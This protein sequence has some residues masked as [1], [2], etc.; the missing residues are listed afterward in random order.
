MLGVPAARRAATTRA[1]SP[2]I[3]YCARIDFPSQ[4]ASSVQ[5][6]HT[7]YELA[8]QGATVILVVRRLLRSRAECFAFYGL[9]EH[10]RLRIVSLALPMHGEFNDWKGDVFRSYLAAFLHRQRSAFTVLMTRDPA[11]MELLALYRTLRPSPG[12]LTLFEVHDGGREFD[13][14]IGARA[15]GLVCTS[16]GARRVLLDSFELST[17]VRVA[18]NG[19]RIPIG[20]DGTPQVVRELNDA[21]R[22]LDVLYAGQLSPGRGIDTLI[23]AM[24]FLAPARLTIVGG[25]D[26]Q[27]V[28]R[29]RALAAHE[30][31]QGR[32]DFAGCVRP[33]AVGAYMDRARVGVVPLRRDAAR[34]VTSPLMLL[35]LMRSGVPIV[36]TDLPAIREI[37]GPEHGELAPADDPRALAAA[38]GRV[39]ADRTHA[40]RLVRAAA[41]RVLDYSWETRARRIL[42]FVHEL[43]PEREGPRPDDKRPDDKRPDDKRPDDKVWYQR[44]RLS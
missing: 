39:L 13:A 2:R 16:D 10:P 24:A 1:T 44:S 5:S 41:T 25:N 23:R 8:R 7:C 32:V 6:L 27:D 20:A 9:P 29:V 43:H 30:G 33:A 38:I 37:L 11:G 17:P 36:A 19:T 26:A 40:A 18:P 3:L 28:A 31:V 22:D 21:Q 42:Q 34:L 4:N 35:E 15:D 12:L 14:G